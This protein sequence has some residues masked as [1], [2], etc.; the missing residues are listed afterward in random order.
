MQSTPV[1]CT[2]AWL[3]FLFPFFLLRRHGARERRRAWAA[4]NAIWLVL[5][6]SEL[7][8]RGAISLGGS[9]HLSIRLLAVFLFMYLWACCYQQ[10]GWSDRLNTNFGENINDAYLPHQRLS[11]THSS[12]NIRNFNILL[13]LTTRL[14][15]K[16][17]CKYK[18]LKIYTHLKY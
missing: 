17:L 5:G 12:F 1:A 14:I 16:K 6:V 2:V 15:K 3:F 10:P 7:W 13:T 18:K 4:S 8:W 9:N 11:Y